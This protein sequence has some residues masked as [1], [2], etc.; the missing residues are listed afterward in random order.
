[1]ADVLV[2]VESAERGGSLITAHLA[3]SYNRD[4]FAFPG[5]AIDKHSQGCNQLIKSNTAGLIESAED[6]ILFMGWEQKKMKPRHQRELFIELE[7]NDKVIFEL[8]KSR[9]EMAMDE[10]CP[11]VSLSQ[12]AVASSLLTLEFE[13][14]VQPLPGKR[15]RL[16]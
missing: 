12:G 14:L 1:M 11:E 8:L 4:V 7:G 13:G 6:L 3:D 2:V 5:K 9:G 16:T 10:I 15:Y